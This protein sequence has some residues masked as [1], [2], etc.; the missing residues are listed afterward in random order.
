MP[1]LKQKAA[2]GVVWTLCEK[3]SGQTGGF[4]VGMALARLLTPTNC[5]C[6]GFRLGLL[7]DESCTMM[8]KERERTGA[9]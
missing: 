8:G 6:A 7:L 4:V 2:K 3:L 9:F 1:T 5:G